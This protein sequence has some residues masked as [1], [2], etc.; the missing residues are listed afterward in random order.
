MP[1]KQGGMG[2]DGLTRCFEQR[3]ASAP[4]HALRVCTT[5][6]AALCMYVHHTGDGAWPDGLAGSLEQGPAAR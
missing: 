4:W 5:Q 3:R 1:D 6:E 2:P